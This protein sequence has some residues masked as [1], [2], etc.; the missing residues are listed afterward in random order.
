MFDLR[1]HSN[2]L[3]AGRF[4]S[5]FF[6]S[7]DVFTIFVVVEMRKPIIIY[8][9]FWVLPIFF[10]FILLKRMCVNTQI[11][12]QV[13]TAIC[14]NSRRQDLNE[15]KPLSLKVVLMLR[16]QGKFVPDTARK[17]NLK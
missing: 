14:P 3:Q 2:L 13:N 17:N 5:C 10:C 11:F 16:R 7:G 15:Y 12:N 4:Y 9:I 8:F 6:Y 1:T